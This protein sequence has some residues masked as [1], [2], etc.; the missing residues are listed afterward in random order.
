MSTFGVVLVTVSSREEA[1]SL[2][3]HLVNESLAACVNF[4]PIHS[5]YSWQGT[6]RHDD[7]WQMVIKT[8][9]D[10]FNLLVAR[11]KELHSYEVPEVIAL[12]IAQG[13]K[14]Y[15]DWLAEQTTFR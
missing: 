13:S 9:L 2:A 8:N 6:I 12:N 14:P 1:L 7:E 3:D 5:V 11:V 4:F 15:L 10:Y